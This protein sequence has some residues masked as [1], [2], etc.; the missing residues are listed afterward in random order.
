MSFVCVLV[1]CCRICGCLLVV[2]VRIFGMV[3]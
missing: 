1:W 2:F 3:V